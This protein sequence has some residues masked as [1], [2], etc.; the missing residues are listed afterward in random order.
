M[1]PSKGMT[2]EDLIASG[3]VIEV[4]GKKRKRD[5]TLYRTANISHTTWYRWKKLAMSDAPEGPYKD[6]RAQL[7]QAR[8][9]VKEFA[10]SLLEDI[11]TGKPHTT[12]RCDPDGN[13]LWTQTTTAPDVKACIHL[14]SALFPETDPRIQAQKL[15]HEQEKERYKEGLVALPV[16]QVEL[17]P[18]VQNGE[19]GQ[20]DAPEVEV[21]EPRQLQQQATE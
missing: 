10:L 16:I 4:F 21:V 18:P 15:A 19:N 5:P 3:L 2:I 13:L 1:P 17:L 7:D 14:L 8:G 9:M 11:A 6:L 12:K 20:V